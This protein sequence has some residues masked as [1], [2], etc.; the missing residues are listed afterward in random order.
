MPSGSAELA[1]APSPPMR[2]VAI[3]TPQLADD[4]AESVGVTR[5]KTWLFA[6]LCG[7]VALAPLPLASARPLA[8]DILGL[9]VAVLLGLGMALPAAEIGA[10]ARTLGVPIALFA[11]V[12]LFV[13]VQ[14]SPWTPEAWH[15]ALWD[16][17]A[18]ALGHKVRGSIAV[19]PH[20]ALIGLYRFLAYAGLLLLSYLLCR[21]RLRAARALRLATL[22]GGGY[23]AYGLVAYWSGNGKILWLSKWAYQADLTSTFVNRNSFAAY[24]G[25]T[26]VA[27]LAQAFVIF[28]DLRLTGTRRQKLARLIESASTHV[29][30]I[31]L[32]FLVATALFLTHSR[33]GLLATAIGIMVLFVAM[34][35]APSIG[36]MRRLGII[37]FILAMAGLAFLVSG[38]ALL[39]RLLEAGGDVQGRMEMYTTT[40]TAFGEHPLLGWGLGS[41]TSV[42][43]VFRPSAIVEGYVNAAHDSYLENLLELGLPAS[44]ALFGALLWLVGLAVRGIRIRRRDAIY[45]CVAVAASALVA[46]HSTVDFSLQIPAVTATYMLL[47][48]VAVAQSRSSVGG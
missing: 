9:A 27:A 1:D 38:E 16:Q 45:P 28:K 44:L 15:N 47:L 32:V 20:A 23:A 4:A 26:L 5:L 2:N 48:G 43:P 35:L 13:V 31:V 41:F 33:G 21:D 34:S 19:D 7:V 22:S 17:A 29:W 12:A 36:M 11:A 40:E 8:W 30:I 37:A 10:T 6:G 42:F 46:S 24:L 18:E 25:L 14:A 3:E 39:G